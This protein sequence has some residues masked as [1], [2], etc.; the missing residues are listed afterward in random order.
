MKL[1]FERV[2]AHS[3]NPYVILDKSL[4]IRWANEAYLKATESRWSEIEGRG[5]FDA[6]PSQ[7]ESYDQ[8][9]SSFDR[10]LKKGEQDEIARIP[11]AIPN[12][13]GGF[14]THVWSATHTPFLDDDGNVE[15]ILQHTVR[16]TAIEQSGSGRDTAG[17]VR[18]AEA[19]QQRY[20][21]VSKELE[22]FRA[23]L[24][25]APGFV[26]VLS[27][28]N[29]RFVMANAAYRQL[30]GEREVVGKTVAEALPEI[31]DQ[32]FIELLDTVLSNDKPYFGQK[33]R[34][35]LRTG[36]GEEL[37]TR[38]LEF[39]YQPIHGAKGFEGILVQGHDVTEEVAF[40]E[41]QR[42]LI[43][44]LNHR[45]KNTLAVVQG[46]AKQSFRPEPDSNA[47]DV[48][49]DRLA[50]LASAHNLLTER[51]W[52]S[53][54]LELIVKGSLEATA[55]M[56]VSRYSLEGPRVVLAPQT[57]VTLAMVVHELCTNAL[58]YGA[59]SNEVGFMKISWNTHKKDG[60]TVL[61]FEWTET[62]GP[63]VTEPAE[64]GFGTRLIKRGLGGPDG[65]TSLEYRTSG[66]YCRIEG[67][68]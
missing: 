14:D 19:V 22:R 1:D 48:F 35:L 54:D 44:E 61:V 12:E 55:G 63:S 32:G 51:S 45:V 68:I 49:S 16:I 38:F 47:I 8:L 60:D 50:A 40:E 2:L 58:K 29:H 42:V 46:L 36:D 52:E 59:L 43:N 26:A 10:V 53:A 4:I 66:L 7:G 30:I 6:F 31:V 56:N 64:F 15:Y 3:P 25:Q 65:H 11:Y 17:I 41:H 13:V 62:G 34:V 5:V 20:L 23:M 28:K 18:R 33:E 57:A 67:T 27:G 9:K 37:E 39:I 21:G 24:E